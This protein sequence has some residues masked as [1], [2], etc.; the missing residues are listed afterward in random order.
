MAPRFAYLSLFGILK[1]E[2]P[3]EKTPSSDW[4]VASPKGVGGED[5]P[6]FVPAAGERPETNIRRAAF[7]QSRTYSA[8]CFLSVH[9][10]LKPYAGQFRPVGA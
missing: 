9:V 2:F 10:G 1:K 4:K 5:I 8:L 3:F 6:V 7:P